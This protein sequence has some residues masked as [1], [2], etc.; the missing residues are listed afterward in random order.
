MP[1]AVR[2]VEGFKANFCNDLNKVNV[3]VIGHFCKHLSRQRLQLAASN[4]RVGCLQVCAVLPK[5]S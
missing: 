3:F 1:A 2:L 5:V 4:L